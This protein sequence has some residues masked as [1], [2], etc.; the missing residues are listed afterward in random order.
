MAVTTHNE[1]LALIHYQQ[2][3]QPT[4]PKSSDGIGQDDKQQLIWGYPGINWSTPA[5]VAVR[6]GQRGILM[7]RD[8]F[9]LEYW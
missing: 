1:K 9:F 7:G 6:R 8:D 2:V 3:F 4:P 5:S